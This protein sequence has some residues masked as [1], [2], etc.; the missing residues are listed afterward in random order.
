MGSTKTVTSLD[1]V[2]TLVGICPRKTHHGNIYMP[3]MPGSQSLA[4]T[5]WEEPMSNR[6]KG[7]PK[8]S[9]GSTLSLRQ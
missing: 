5:L 8:L 2:I 1:F 3:A 6:R 4:L 7:I 9:N